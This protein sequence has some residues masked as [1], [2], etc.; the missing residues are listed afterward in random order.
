MAKR[1]PAE[2]GNDFT[3]AQVLGKQLKRDFSAIF[4]PFEGWE[5][6]EAGKTKGNIQGGT[7]VSWEE[8]Y[9]QRNKLLKDL[10]LFTISGKM[11]RG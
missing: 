8:Q 3:E 9:I 2:L 6:E 11:K 4:G 1:N 5:L 10:E 7:S